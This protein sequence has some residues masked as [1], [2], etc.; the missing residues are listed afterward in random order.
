MIPVKLLVNPQ[1]LAP[2][3]SKTVDPHQEEDS[4][5]LMDYLKEHDLCTHTAN[6]DTRLQGNARK[7]AA[8]YVVCQI[9][10]TLSL[11][12][13]DILKTQGIHQWIQNQPINDSMVFFEKTPML[14]PGMLWEA[15]NTGTIQSFYN[16]V[17][18]IGHVVNQSA[19]EQIFCILHTLTDHL[20]VPPK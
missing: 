16:A 17:E 7:W 11:C 8:W 6:L 15:C 14:S 3:Y 18:Q 9:Q 19:W 10:K 5:V 1:V 12:H 4:C 20:P 13:V 2:R